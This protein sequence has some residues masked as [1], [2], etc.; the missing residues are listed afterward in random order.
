LENDLQIPE[1]KRFS[2]FRFLFKTVLWCFSITLVLAVIAVS[3]VFIY[4]NE[5]KSAIIGELNKN[6]RSEVNVEPVNIDLTVIKSFPKCALE[7]KDVLI[8]EAVEKK[9]RDTLIF[10]RDLL[11]MFNLKD[12]WNKNYTINKIDVKDAKANLYIDKKGNPNYIFWKKSESKAGDNLKFALE[13]INLSG[14]DLNYKN[15]EKKIKFNLQFSEAEFSGRFSDEQYAMTSAGRAKL[16]YLHVNKTNL[17]RQKNL[18]YDIGLNI[19]K[20]NYKIEKAELS[21][22][23]MNF[24]IEGDVNYKDSLETADLSFAGRKLDIASVLSLLPEKYSERINDYN[25]EGNFFSKGTINYKSGQKANVEAEFG[26]NDATVT[27]KQ[28]DLAM[29]HLNVQGQLKMNDKEDYLNLQNISAELGSNTISGFCLVTNLS[30]PYLNL[31]AAVNAKLEDVNNFWPIDTLQY[32]SGSVQLNAA[33]K[34]NLNE[35][36][37]SA[38]SPNVSAEGSATLK[39]IKTKFKGKENEI[40]IS[41]GSFSLN[42]RNVIVNNFKMIAGSSDIEL[43]GELPGFLNY[44]FDPKQPLVIKADLKSNKIVLEDLLYGG[45]KTTNEP[46]NIPANLNFRLSA[47]VA[48]FSFS[49]FEA[50]DLAGDISVFEQKVIA[51]NVSL[52]TMDG[53]ATLNGIADASGS[54][55]RIKAES[56]LENINISKLFYECNNFGQNTLNEKHLKGFTTSSIIFSGKWSKTLE[57]DPGSI[58]ASGSLAIQQGRLVDFKPLE[59]LAKYVEVNELKDI[60]FSTLQSAF[61]IRNQVITI[62]RTVIKNSALNVELWG[63][64]TFNNEIDYHIKLLLSELI[65]SRK[66]ANKQLDEEMEFV[67]NDPENRRCVYVLMT[68]TVDNPIIKYDKRGLKQKI[69]EDIKAEKQNL[70]QLFKEEFGLF[71]KDSALVKNETPKAEQKFKIEF[72]DSKENLPGGKAGKKPN[73]LKPKKKEEEDDDF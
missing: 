11:L 32:V 27:Y 58:V 73:D 63:K 33:I 54:D 16:I 28:K 40:N 19:N 57:P 6:L 30:D 71:K 5:V 70:K 48:N 24:A 35:M 25:S 10:A 14:I 18:H 50:Q 67:E 4:E 8:L 72:G 51:S 38:F 65:T 12:L 31:N 66:R 61:D 34:G 45:E 47:L 9:E 43:N 46:V 17:L 42:N 55:I 2:L 44:L 60:R 52:K 56:D 26:I 21:L 39:D 7:F 29:K 64:H 1:K 49:K 22:N 62:P 68:G 23:E 13:K 69:G 53:R 15:A 41:E 37:R 36:R 59:S 3:L 20:T